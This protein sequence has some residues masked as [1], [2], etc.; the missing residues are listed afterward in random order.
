MKK[1]LLSF[2]L[3]STSFFAHA[4]QTIAIMGAMDV[5]IE[6]LLPS[7]QNSQEKTIGGHSYYTGMIED[8]NVVVTRS[9]VGK[10]NAAITTT[11][12][13]REFNADKII[14]TGIAGAVD[15][16][17]NP[18][19]VVVSTGLVQHDVD[20]TAFNRPK[21]LLPEYDDR[22]FYSDKAL[23]KIAFDAASAVV[24]DSTE[25]H[26]V[27]QGV[28]ATGDQFIANKEVV[29]HLYTEFNA[30]AVEME[31]AAVAQA[32]FNFNVP[33]VVIRTISDKAD[34]SAHMVYSEL[35]KATADNSA[36]ITLKML[37]GL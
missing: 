15:P 4:T 12:L 3:F 31:G 18:L 9:G 10:V 32:A 8:K 25:K 7:I 13:I 5:E 24:Q 22:F 21:G 19:D 6:A 17:L 35:K 16:K 27:Y 26:A 28:I 36:A 34:G 2:I 14:F 20:L 33:F 29:H 1:Y 30:M 23:N 37:Q 11:V